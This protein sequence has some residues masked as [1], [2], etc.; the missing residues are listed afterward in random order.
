MKASAVI[1]LVV[2]AVVAAVIVFL[3]VRF[4]VEEQIRRLLDWVDDQGFVGAVVFIVAYILA[5]VLFIPGSLLT[6][7]AG[8][9]FGLGFGTVYISIASTIGAFF[10]FLAGRYLA[11]GWVESK[12]AGNTRFKAVDEAVGNEGWKIVL[13]TRLSPIFPFNMLNYAYG[14]TG[15]KAREYF[16]ASWIGMLPGTVM[17]VYLGTLAGELATLGAD[18][19]A[20]T[21]AEW[22]LLGVGFVATV[23][24]TIFV[25]RVARKALNS[26]ID[27]DETAEE[28]QK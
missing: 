8:A 10:A 20:R 4:D 2:V 6:L 28:T 22:V 12:I 1:R 21:P 19:G 11:R 16:F 25:T 15:V 24:V 5:T 14:V 26:R 18:D 17:Y 9:V 27:L 23:A 13:L 3:F 7:G